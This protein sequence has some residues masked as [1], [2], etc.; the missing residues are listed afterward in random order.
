M[1]VDAKLGV[2]KPGWNAV[3]GGDRLPVA[4]ATRALGNDFLNP[5][6]SPNRGTG[7]GDGAREAEERLDAWNAWKCL[8]VQ[9]DG[10]DEDVLAEGGD[11][12][13]QERKH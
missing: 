11:E 4:I 12:D 13:E 1:S 2:A 7:L 3:A 6:R 8:L 9:A 5:G 10:I